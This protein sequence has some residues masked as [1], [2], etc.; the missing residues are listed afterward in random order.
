MRFMAVLLGGTLAVTG[1]PSQVGPPSVEISNGSIVATVYLPDAK[2]GGYRGTRFDWSGVIGRLEYAGHRYYGPWF[3]RV[4]PAVRDFIYDGADIV[5]GAQSAITGPVEEFST[6]GQGLGF[7]EAAP[8]GT[9]VKIGVGTLRKPD[10]GAAYSMFRSYDIVDHGTWRTRTAPDEVEFTQD[11]MDASSG[12]GY[13]YTKA[14]RLVAGQPELVM[15]HR[16]QNRGRRPIATTVYNHNFLVLDGAAPGPGLVITAPF[17]LAVPRPLDPAMAAVQ[18]RQLRYLKT[19]AG[20]DRVS[21]PL[22]GFGTSAD[23]YHFTIEDRRAGA[24]VEIAGDRP[25]SR[26][27]LWSIRSVVALEP[28][29]TMAIAPGTDFTW[30]YRYRYFT[31]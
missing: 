24:G 25:L 19:L 9:F 6:D 2:A 10:D 16:L 21:S 15:T 8:G 13:T 5:A 12:Y 20:E 11:L 17:A 26:L 22:E 14:I 27:Q 29:I 3:T 1:A 30:T 28:F 18:G 7:A 4:D 23:D 31:R